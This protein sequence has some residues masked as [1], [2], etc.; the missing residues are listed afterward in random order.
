[1]SRSISLSSQTHEEKG[2]G[3]RKIIRIN[4]RDYILRHKS[5]HLDKT[6][7]IHRLKGT[8][9]ASKHGNIGGLI[10]DKKLKFVSQP[11]NTILKN[12]STS[13]KI[14]LISPLSI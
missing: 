6:Y 4:K 9:R 1:M 12:G 14:V 11:I 3:S 10:F 7:R 13:R 2:L 5:V 8:S